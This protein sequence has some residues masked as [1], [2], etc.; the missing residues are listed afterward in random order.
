MDTK[1]FEFFLY[2]YFGKSKD[3]LEA[4][5]N[6]AYGDM[7]SHT[8]IGFN[9]LEKG[10]EIKKDY[11][12]TATKVIKE[13]IKEKLSG[14][15]TDEDFIHWHS[16]L[17][18]EIRVVYKEIDFTYGHAQKWINMTLKYLYMFY[19][20]GESEVGKDI[21][22]NDEYKDLDLTYQLDNNTK[23]IVEKTY[24][25]YH[26]PLDNY[27]LKRVYELKNIFPE[28]ETLEKVK[29]NKDGTTYKLKCGD[30]Q[31]AW[32]KLPFD[33]KEE[34]CEA[35]NSLQSALRDLAR[36]QN[37]CAL[38]WEFSNW[39]IGAVKEQYSKNR[40]KEK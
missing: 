17:C 5:I 19:S 32:S 35:Y 6:N 16:K 36:E 12:K 25:F 29:I 40:V 15:K 4:A 39:I 10:D 37:K 8:L 31:Y 2:S 24:K 23:A 7:A 33:D 1:V 30:K 20:V 27:I 14:C 21:F 13:Y 11:R 9:N 22:V 28:S 38:E 18:K 26:V 34:G 3:A